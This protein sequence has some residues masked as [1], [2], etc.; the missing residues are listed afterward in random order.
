MSFTLD[1]L[2]AFA[3]SG[4]QLQVIQDGQMAPVRSRKQ[5]GSG[6]QDL[7]FHPKVAAKVTER[8]PFG[9]FIHICTHAQ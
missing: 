3:S 7:P 8:I 5:A 4:Q 2:F 1:L 6:S 9:L